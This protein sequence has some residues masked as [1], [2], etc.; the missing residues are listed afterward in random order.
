MK[1]S[2]L[3]RQARALIE[4]PAHWWDGRHDK[5]TFVDSTRLLRS[6]I[7]AIQALQRV[8]N[9]DY[10]ALAACAAGAY[11]MDAIGESGV[12]TIP[13]FNDSHTHAEVLAMWDRAI[14]LAEVAEMYAELGAVVEEAVTV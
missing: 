6:Q 8:S 10:Y 13:R 4:N 5:G 7:C 11:L 1:P 14:E 3:L 12:N 9:T 2:Q